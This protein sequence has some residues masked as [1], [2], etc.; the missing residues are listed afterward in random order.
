[1]HADLSCVCPPNP[2]ACLRSWPLHGLQPAEPCPEL[3]QQL[4]VQ[5]R[6]EVELDVLAG[7]V[8]R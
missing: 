6:L 8:Y 3:C 2:F 7:S 1:M 4:G 5:L